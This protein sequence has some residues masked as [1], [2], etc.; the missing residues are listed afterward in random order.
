MPF[1]IEVLFY[2]DVF[3]EIVVIEVPELLWNG[4]EQFSEANLKQ[5]NL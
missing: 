3:V 4:A 1:W 5:Q 2:M